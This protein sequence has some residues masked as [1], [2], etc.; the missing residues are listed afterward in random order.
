[1]PHGLL[2]QQGS[3]GTG[4]PHF[5]SWCLPLFFRL[6]FF[7]ISADFPPSERIQDDLLTK[8]PQLGTTPFL[9]GFFSRLSASLTQ[10]Y[11]L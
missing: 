8:L 6:P 3:C 5:P 10:G 11:Q 9:F 1:M 2:G 4:G 7:L